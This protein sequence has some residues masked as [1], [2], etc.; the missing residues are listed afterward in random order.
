ME[1]IYELRDVE[2]AHPI[3][4][5][6]TLDAALA[7]VAATA[8]H[9]GDGMVSTW[10]LFCSTPMGAEAE[11]IA[12]GADLARLARAQAPAVSAPMER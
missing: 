4:E 11:V 3:S 9:Y 2:E 6:D 7:V 5:Y 1:T 10:G 12:E 8:D